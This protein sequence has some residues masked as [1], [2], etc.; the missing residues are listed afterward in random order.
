MNRKERKELLKENLNQLATD[1][2]LSPSEIEKF[3]ERWRGGFR[4]YSFH[5]LLLILM[6][7]IDATICAGCRQWNEHGRYVN[8]GE[9]ALWILAPGFKT[10]EKE[11]EE[12]GEVKETKTLAYFF[13][14]PVFDISQ[15]NGEELEI[16][17]TMIE[18]KSDL[19]LDQIKE[20]FGVPFKLSNGIQ[21]ASTDGK[22]IEISAR[23]NP[24]QMVCAYFHEIAH[25]SLGH[26]DGRKC[27]PKD[28]RELEAEATSYIVCKCIGI[29]NEGAKYYISY[30]KGNRRNLEDS[31]MK[32]LRT[33]EKIVNKIFPEKAN[34]LNKETEK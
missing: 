6:Q 1:L 31:S 15:T 13:A 2:L 22:T 18:G 21:D 8:A 23:K 10:E 17:N 33:A 30:W 9:K 27:L 5:N 3:A 34:P 19:T 11:N 7:K 29:D 26:L 12:T 16:G 28:I 20:I 32:V 4:F 24:S 14:V 25:I